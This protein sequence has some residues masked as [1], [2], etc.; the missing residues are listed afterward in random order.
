[1]VLSFVSAFNT[2]VVGPYFARLAPQHVFRNVVAT[3]ILALVIAST[4][5]AASFYA[6]SYI[7]LILGKS[8]AHMVDLIPLFIAQAV[9]SVLSGLMSEINRNRRYMWW[10]VPSLT[11]PCTITIY[12]LSGFSFDVSTSHG[13]ILVIMATILINMTIKSIA[14]SVGI[15]RRVGVMSDPIILTGCDHNYFPGLFCTVVTSA[16][17]SKS[18]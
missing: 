4:L 1:M 3:G 15:D 11:I 5:V 10:W 2:Q 16:F 9:L 17:T 12:I 6:K 8:Y 7:V 14:C 18:G 13:I